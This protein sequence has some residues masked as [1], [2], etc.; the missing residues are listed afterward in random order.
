MSSEDDK[1]LDRES[2]DFFD[3]NIF[4]DIVLTGVEIDQKENVIYLIGKESYHRPV[5]RK[6]FYRL[7]T[8]IHGSITLMELVGLLNELKNVSNNTLIFIKGHVSLKHS[9]DNKNHRNLKYIPKIFK[10]TSL[11]D[12]RETLCIGDQDHYINLILS[13]DDFYEREIQEI[14]MERAISESADYESKH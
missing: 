5:P 11:N 2:D 8:D 10:N 6:S 14:E 13:G 7:F 3:D 1:S 12:Y 4:H 9:P